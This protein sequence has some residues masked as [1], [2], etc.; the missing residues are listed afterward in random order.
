MIVALDDAAGTLTLRRGPILADVPLPEALVPGGPFD[1]R[2]Q[3][4]ALVRLANDVGRYPHLERLLASR[5]SAGRMQRETLEEM[6]RLV[7]E[8]EGSYLFVQGP[9]GSGKTWT[10]ARLIVHLLARGKRV[11]VS[12]TSHK[13]IH[14]LLRESKKSLPR[15]ASSSAG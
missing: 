10:G 6:K 7:D 5:R 13:A 14:N 2:V 4:A 11:G 12:S 8:V 3:Q 9:P 15:Q 1:T